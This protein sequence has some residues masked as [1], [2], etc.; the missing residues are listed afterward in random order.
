[1]QYRRSDFDV[2]N[3]VQVSS[4]DSVRRA[5]NDLFRA[6]WPGFPLDRLEAVFCDFERLFTGQFPG[7]YG[8]DTVYHDL[9]HTL[10]GTL[11][12]ARLLVVHERT[13][14]SEKRLG[15]ERALMAL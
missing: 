9:Q 10:D 2:T 8:C 1:M 3:S 5:V 12:T 6:T 15:A 11:A 7:Y 14:H 4:P 13:H